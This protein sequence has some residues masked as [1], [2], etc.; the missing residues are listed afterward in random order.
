MLLGKNPSCD[1]REYTGGQSCCHHLFSLLD[2]GQVTPWQDRPL[3][4]HHKWRIWYTEVESSPTPISD[5]L[6]FNWG[7]MASPVEYDVP[8]CAEGVYGCSRG[9]DGGWVHSH[10]GTWKV[11]Q[12]TARKTPGIPVKVPANA[13]GVSFVTIHGHCHAPTCISF[14]LW[15]HD[16]KTLV[17][18]QEGTFGKSN[19]TFDEEG[20]LHVPPCVFG[21]EEEGLNPALHLPFNTTLFGTKKCKADYG[22][23]GEMSLWQTYGHFY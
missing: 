15:N 10:N 19:R 7:G 21:S 12:M 9:V 18:R 11:S 14:E 16:T 2:K 13:T 8:K 20:Y 1:L 23:H 22:H 17:C 6:Q 5:V 4:Y 3:I